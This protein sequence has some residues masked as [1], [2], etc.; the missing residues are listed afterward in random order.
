[1][2]RHKLRTQQGNISG[3]GIGPI[4]DDN[5]VIK[6]VFR[7]INGG[8]RFFS[9]RNFFKSFSQQKS[10]KESYKIIELM[11]NENTFLFI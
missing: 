8:K 2:K 1:M 10:M 6:G 4:T 3:F 9:R 5:E 7:I 11:Y